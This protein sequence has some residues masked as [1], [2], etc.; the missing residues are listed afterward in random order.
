MTSRTGIGQLTLSMK[1]G[2][3]PK[4]ICLR[5]HYEDSHPFTT[6]EGFE[7]TTSRLR[8]K[9]SSGQSGRSPFQLPD[10]AG[11]FPNTDADPAG[12]LKIEFKPHGDDLDV[13]FPSHLWRD[14]KKIV[15]QWIDYYRG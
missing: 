14:E 13:V 3:W 10:D 12:W 5:L 6:L 9:T 8:V 2:R 7:M 15:I 4:D 11:R 1:E